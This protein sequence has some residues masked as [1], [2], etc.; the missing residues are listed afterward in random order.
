MIGTIET[1][2]VYRFMRAMYR[3]TKGNFWN[4][5]K[6]HTELQDRSIFILLFPVAS[7]Q[8]SF[9]IGKINKLLLIFNT[10]MY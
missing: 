10:K 3:L 7:I 6:V 8:N 4:I 1:E 5:H 2:A 9:L